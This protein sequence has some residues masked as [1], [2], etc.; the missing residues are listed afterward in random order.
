MPVANKLRPLLHPKAWEMRN[1]SPSLNTA[2]AFLVSADMNT[3]LSR[4][5]EVISASVV[6]AYYGAEDAWLQ[7]PASG[8]LGTFGAGACGEFH[9][10]GPSAVPTAGTLTTLQTNLTIPRDLR[11]HKIRI[12]AGPN[13]GQEFTIKS[14][15]IGANSVIT[16]TIAAA[17]AFTV[18]SAFTLRTGRLWV[19]I[20]SATAPAFG[21]YDWALNTWTARAITGLPAS[22]T[23]EGQ[24]VGVDSLRS[25]VLLSG[26]ASAGTATTITIAG[27]PVANAL[28]NLQVRITA[29]TGAGQVRVI[30]SNAGNVLTVPAWTTNPDATSQYAIEG[31]DNALY[32]LGNNAVTLYKYSISANTWATVAPTVARA[33]APGAGMTADWMVGV[34]A[35]ADSAGLWNDVTQPLN[36][37][38]IYSLR[39]GITN[40][41]DRYDIALNSW[42]VIAYGNQSETF[43]T[44]TNSTAVRERI[45]INKDGGNRF[46]YF[47]VVMNALRPF[48]TLLYGAGAATVGDKMAV[49]DYTDGSEINF[50]Y[51]RRASGTELFRMAEIK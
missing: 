2:G 43:T 48:T 23:L 19:F 27:A 35:A 33:A 29:G 44:G 41:L 36:G 13:A 49:L 6:Y 7:L 34:L 21:Y 26:S 22:F 20:P 16:T 4:I 37:R 12:T 28:A 10:D 25:G 51:Y 17:A 1:P 50:L 38:Y 45:Y 42:A 8:F 11:G 32:L 31:D 47:D 15:T 39:G 40:V 3:Q 5:F 30:T 18:A 9:P 24:L 46:F 14:N